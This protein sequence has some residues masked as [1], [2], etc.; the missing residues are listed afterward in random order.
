MSI[1]LIYNASFSFLLWWKFC[2]ILRHLDQVT[3]LIAFGIPL[4]RPLSLPTI[5]NPSH[6]QQRRELGGRSFSISLSRRLSLS[7]AK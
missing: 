4:K 2:L 5:E 3:P 7:V 1:K 6:F